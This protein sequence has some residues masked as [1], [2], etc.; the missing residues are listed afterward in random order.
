MNEPRARLPRRAVHGVLLLDKPAGLSSNDALQKARRLYRAEKAG[1]TGTLDPLASGL[2]PVCFGAATKF[3][4][5]SLDADKA[6][7][8]TLALGATTTTGDAEGEVVERRPVTVDR[9]AIDAACGRFV[10]PIEQVPPMHSALK[11]QGRALYEYA[12]AGVTVERAPRRVTVQRL[13]VVAFDGA[14]LVLDVACSKGTYVRTL[15][16]DLGA[17]LGCGAH[18]AALRR[19]ASGALRVDDAVD[20]EALAAM[21]EQRRD[22]LLLPP[23]VLVEHWP[24]VALPDDEAGR[25]LTGLRRRVRLPDAPAVRVYGPQPRAFLGSAHITAGELIADRL[26]SPAEVAAV[27]D[28]LEP[29]EPS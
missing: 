24:R 8:A 16:E 7:R 17:A 11:H 21:D 19:T 4:Q 27:A 25:F 23:D 14:T 26:L 12:R 20:L 15:A 28:T 6:Y 13:D 10:G 5:A 22:A 3:A 29:R 9:T 18:L 2:L 1:H